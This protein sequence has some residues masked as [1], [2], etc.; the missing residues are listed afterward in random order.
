METTAKIKFENDQ[1]FLDGVYSM[2]QMLDTW[3]FTTDDGT[4]R[5]YELT[6]NSKELLL[7]V[8]LRVTK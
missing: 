3:K 6:P 8:L 2:G 4:K 1:D 5:H 7:E